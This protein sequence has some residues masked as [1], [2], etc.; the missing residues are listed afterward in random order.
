VATSSSEIVITC[1]VA[2][3]VFDGI[4]S[5]TLPFCYDTSNYMA[6]DGVLVTEGVMSY[7]YSGGDNKI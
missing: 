6:G 1:R 3:I 5:N 2:S 7:E 4:S